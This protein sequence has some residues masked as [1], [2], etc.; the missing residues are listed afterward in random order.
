LRLLKRRVGPL[1]VEV[2][3]R[4]LALP[5]AQIEALGEALLDFQSLAEATDWL[6]QN[7]AGLSV[8]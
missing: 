7:A 5:Q 6:E 3:T 8:N 1:P 4:V 2:E